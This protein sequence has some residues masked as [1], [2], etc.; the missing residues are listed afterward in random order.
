LWNLLLGILDKGVLTLGDNRKVDF[1]RAMIFMTSNL[2]AAEMSQIGNPKMGFARALNQEV[3]AAEE[4]QKRSEKQSKTGV[5]A[6]RKKFTPE[7]MNRLD[8][9]VVFKSLADKDLRRILDIELA[10]F[11]QR[12]LAG[13]NQKKFVFAVS[14][15]AKGFLLEQGVDPRYGARH[16][17]RSMERLLVQPLSNLLATEQVEG[18]DCLRIEYDPVE[19][20]LTFTKE[21][22]GLPIGTMFE[23][24]DT[25]V[26][27]QL[28]A[29]AAAVASD[30]PKTNAATSLQKLKGKI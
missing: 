1:S 17:K 13:A 26:P 29:L 12:L 30:Q 24:I 11:Q 5:E 18:G 7:F 16:L 2:G 8:K 3:L 6:A 23:M 19:R 25:S 15:E 22:E 14:D 21:A 10:I 4:E 20:E 27:V 28:G 9:I